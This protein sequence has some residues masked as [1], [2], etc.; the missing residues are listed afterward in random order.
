MKRYLLLSIIS[1]FLLFNVDAFSQKTV[2]KGGLSEGDMTIGG[3][4][5]LNLPTGDFGDGA[6]TSFGLAGQYQYFVLDQVSIL[7]T[8][9]FHP[10]SFESDVISGNTLQFTVGGRYYF[11]SGQSFNIYGG[12]DLG[13]YTSSIEVE[14]SGFFGGSLGS[15]ETSLGFDINV[16]G[17]VP[18]NDQLF[19][20]GNLGYCII[21]GD[22]EI[23][24]FRLTA[25]IA[26][27]L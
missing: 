7:G 6:N 5:Q 22:T 24:F 9:G 17:L 21:G 25:G 26:Y 14:S 23:D 4:V 2:S 27:K 13:L 15:D 8:I 10:W 1:V 16:G 3:R 18:I 12:L 19:F 20:D 11:T